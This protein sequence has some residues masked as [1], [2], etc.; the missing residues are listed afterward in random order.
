MGEVQTHG[1]RG[2]IGCFSVN[3]INNERA[4]CI[5]DLISAIFRQA[6]TD[7]VYYLTHGSYDEGFSVIE[8]V[9][10]GEFARYAAL[11]IALEPNQLLKKF[12][13]NIALQTVRKT[14][15]VSPDQIRKRIKH[16]DLGIA[17]EKA[18]IKYA[19]N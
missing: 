8:F 15:Q 16:K 2:Y 13:E 17:F 7:E 18:L 14:D 1:V 12:W 3:E 4:K 10:T 5:E 11:L 9:K 19:G 6:V